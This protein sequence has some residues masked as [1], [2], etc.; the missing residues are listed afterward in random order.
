MVSDVWPLARALIKSASEKTGLGDFERTEREV[1]AG[2]QLLW[3]A[4][5]GSKIEAAA[6]TQLVVEAGRKLC[7]LVACGGDGRD[8]WLPLIEGIESY[9]RDEGCAAMLIGGRP[10]WQRVLSGY[11]VK[12][13]VLEKGL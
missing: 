3:L 9:A 1:L 13:V 11:A 7:V 6:V 5:D 10:G 8:R 4:H 2:L 12:S